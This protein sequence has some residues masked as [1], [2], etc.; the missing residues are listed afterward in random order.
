LFLKGNQVKGFG[1]FGE[2]FNSFPQ[3]VMGGFW[4]LKKYMESF[5]ISEGRIVEFFSKLIF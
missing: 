2:M 3:F 1:N 4:L 5:R